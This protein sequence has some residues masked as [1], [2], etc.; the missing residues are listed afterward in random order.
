MRQAPL[1]EGRVLGP[2][3]IVA[4][5][6]IMSRSEGRFPVLC[7][8]AALAGVS[9]EQILQGSQ[10]VLKSVLGKELYRSLRAE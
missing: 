2:A 4:A 3:I 1:A 8:L 7:R 10:R 6:V 5:L 9:E